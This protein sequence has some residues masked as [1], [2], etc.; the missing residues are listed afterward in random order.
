MKFSRLRMSYRTQNHLAM[1]KSRTGIAP[2][3]SGRF[4]MCLSLGDPSPPNPDEY[5]EKGS[6]I[7]PL[8]LFGNYE[9]IYMALFV[10]RLHQDG[11]DPG[12]YLNRMVRA[13]L[14]RG[15]TMLFARIRRLDDFVR[16][17]L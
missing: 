7:S 15:A 9:D 10:M 2:N 1:I 16:I 13:H 17:V 3:V 11:L 8:T 14:N 6:E 5:D 12:I 4:A